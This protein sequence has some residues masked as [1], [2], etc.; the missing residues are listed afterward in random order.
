MYL[1]LLL[2]AASFYAG[3]TSATQ[4]MHRPV[5]FKS[6]Y[7]PNTAIHLDLSISLNLN[8]LQQCTFEQG[9]KVNIGYYTNWAI[10]G[11]N[12]TPLDID[13]ESLTHIYYAFADT[14]PLT[15]QAILT[16]LWSDQQIT[17]P[18]DDNT[19][20]GNNL[21]GNLKQLYLLKQKKRS[22]KTILSFGGWTYSQAGHFNFAANAT[23]RATF[24]KTA[25]QLL[26]DNGFDGIDIDWEY[27]TAGEQADSFVAL[28]KET[29]A[30]LD[31]HA[32][33][34]GDTVPYELN[35]AVSAGAQNYQNLKV[36]DMDEYL[37]YWNLM[38]YDYSGSWSEVSDYQANVYGGALSGVSTSASTEWYLKEGASKKK[39]VVGMPIYGRGFENTNGIFQSFNGTGPGT[40]EA[41][42]YD[43]KALPFANTTIYNDLKNISSYSY[44]PVKKQLITYDTPIIT[45]AKST[46]L[47]NQGLA[48]AMFWELSADKNGTDSL[49]WTAAKTMAKL[50]NTENHLSYPG[51][52]FDNIRAGMKAV[53]K[54]GHKVKAKYF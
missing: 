29:R 20:A 11:R 34:K 51:S 19:A 8:A 10:Y 2:S 25:I 6:K 7:T 9:G 39:F 46:W 37:T 15:G 45:E 32:K 36:K 24:V 48:G 5:D 35:A 49:V 30:G 43:Y 41:G 47:S 3:V 14:D 52:Q 18:G 54:R 44:D 38:G 21:Y 22:L 23:S 31:A 42:V 50:D 13:I 1:T 17:Y 16:D 27:P 4:V 26:E 28:L 33:S 12:Y 53:S 40:W